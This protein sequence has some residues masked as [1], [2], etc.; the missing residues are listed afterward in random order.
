M[1]AKDIASAL[2]ISYSSVIKVL[3][4]YRPDRITSNSRPVTESEKER[5]FL[6]LE[7]RYSIPE[8]SRM[9]KL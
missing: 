2:D 1:I 6:L 5:V 3:K 4:E 8:I 9:T 7:K